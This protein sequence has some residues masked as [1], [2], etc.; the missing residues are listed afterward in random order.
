MLSIFILLLACSKEDEDV[1]DLGYNY[2][3]VETGNYIVYKVEEL[4]YNEFDL[5][6][7]TVNYWLK[8]LVDSAIEPSYESGKAYQLKR[9]TRA[10]DTLDW[11]YKDVWVVHDDKENGK[12]TRA[13]EDSI[14]VKMIFPYTRNKSWDGNA[15]NANVEQQIYRVK[16]YDLQMTLKLKPNDTSFTHTSQINQKENV[17]LI[18]DQRQDE[19]Y[20]RGVG[21][22]LKQDIDLEMEVDGT[23]KGGHDYKWIYAEHG[24][25]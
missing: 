24:K 5:T 10:N 21:L 12:V 11:E 22:I 16:T 17:N 4:T 20:A 9:Y 18:E 19:V 13:E 23:I 6:I 2:Y 3:P 25:E 8:E 7:D 14:F 15:M 1:I